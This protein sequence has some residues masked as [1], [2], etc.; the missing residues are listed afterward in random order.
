MMVDYHWYHGSGELM[1]ALLSCGVSNLN[2]PTAA[3]IFSTNQESFGTSQ[4]LFEFSHPGENF[5]DESGEFW[6]DQALS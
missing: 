5:P 6:K 4:A 1:L 2:S 3:R